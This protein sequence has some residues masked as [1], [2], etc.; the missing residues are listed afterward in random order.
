MRT[1]AQS[2]T[3]RPA[4]VEDA[5]FVALVMMEA[6]GHDLMERGEMPGDDLVETCLSTDTLYSYCNATIFE[7][8]GEPVGG[9]IAYDG[10]GYH[11]V[12]VATFAPIMHRLD[13]NPLEMDDETRVGEYYLDSAAVLPEFRGQGIGR[14]IIEYGVAIA[15]QRGLLPV[16]ACDPDNTGAHNLYES[17]GFRDSGTMYIFAHTYLRMTFPLP[18]RQ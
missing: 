3:C 8:E 14:R 16:L 10:K 7:I 12:K 17:I 18:L 6:V 13:F 5:R 1:M 4:T 9:L 11:E 2:L 15:R